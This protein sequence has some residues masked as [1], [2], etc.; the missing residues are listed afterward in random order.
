MPSEVS[1]R[2]AQLAT[3]VP[4][5]LRPGP[6]SPPRNGLVGHGVQAVTYEAADHLVVRAAAHH[7]AAFTA[8]ADHLVALAA[9]QA[10]TF[11]R[12]VA[13]DIDFLSK[14]IIDASKPLSE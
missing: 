14:R 10:D 2:A 8:A 4:G 9:D 1:G 3:R 12:V 13:D 5:V 6:Q 7:L 11:P